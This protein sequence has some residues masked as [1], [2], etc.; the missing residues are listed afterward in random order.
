MAVIK[1]IEQKVLPLFLQ[2]LS[3]VQKR[4]DGHEGSFPFG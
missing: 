4:D 1:T 3:A 2:T